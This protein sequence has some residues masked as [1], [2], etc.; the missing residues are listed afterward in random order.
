MF[1]SNLYEYNIILL[2]VY[3]SHEYSIS[4]DSLKPSI[5]FLSG[6]TDQSEN[7]QT[8]FD[9]LFVMFVFHYT[10][11]VMICD[12][13]PIHI[14]VLCIHVIMCNNNNFCIYINISI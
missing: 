5:K 11:Y 8:A 3:A 6:W 13:F 2:H 7:N 14:S 10:M 9:S 1:C 4:G 12:F